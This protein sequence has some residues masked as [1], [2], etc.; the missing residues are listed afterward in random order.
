MPFKVGDRVVHRS[1]KK[2]RNMVV[3]GIA[4]KEHPPT[5]RHNELANVGQISDGSYYCTW[6]S[7]AK[8]GESYFV[9]AELELLKE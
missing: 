8:K 9:D 4:R 1:D 5:T 3:A 7:G 2:P 6:I